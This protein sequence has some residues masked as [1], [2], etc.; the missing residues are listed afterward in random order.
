MFARQNAVTDPP[1]SRMDL[2]ACRNLLIYLEPVLQQK[3][4]PMLHYALHPWGALWLGQ[5]ETVGSFRDMFDMASAKHKFYFKKPNVKAPLANFGFSARPSELAIAATAQHRRATVAIARRR[6]DARRR[7]HSA[8]ALRACGCAGR[9]QPRNPSVSWRHGA[10]SCA[11]AR[12]AP[13]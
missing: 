10:L 6:S 5:S 1:F 7:S 11:R 9:R 4:I 2:V 12:A 8:C 13:A 3:L